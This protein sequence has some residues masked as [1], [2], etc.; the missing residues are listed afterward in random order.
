MAEQSR[1]A[2]F[3]TSELIHSLLRRWWVVALVTVVVGVAAYLYARSLP[4]FFKATINCVPPRSDNSIMG[5]AL[6]GLSNTLKDIGLSKM[7]GKSS[8]GYEFI[9][10]LYTRALRDSMIKRYK[11]HEEYDLQGESMLSVREEFDKNLEIEYMQ[12]GN[13]TITIWSR[14][15]EKAAEMC[16]GFV[17]EANAITNRVQRE[18]ATKA[19]SYLETRMAKMDS[20]LNALSDS[21]AMFARKYLIF[22]PPDQARAASTALATGKAQ[23]LQQETL[24]GLLQQ[25]YGADD[26]QVRTQRQLVTE[27]QKQYSRMETQ[28]GIAGKLSI[29]DGAGV[30][31]RYMRVYSEFEAFSRIK[32][33][34]MPTLE[35][36]HLDMNKTSPSLLVID[37]PE[38][39]EKKDKPKR[40]LIAGGAALGAGILTTCWFMIAFAWS[41]YKRTRPQA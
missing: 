25:S 32:A 39:A 18:E 41:Q 15:P 1:P 36:T 9:V 33:F 3:P 34:L 27:L 2:S 38:P 12:E 11:L 8:E 29:S 7:A 23:V 5:N 4:V 13:Y 37:H 10:L 17:E 28:P 30:G 26:P 24:L 35:Q 31:V 20:S 14:S 22:S 19:A 6:G 40:T 21:L 16:E